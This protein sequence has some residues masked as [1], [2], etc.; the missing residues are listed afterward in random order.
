MDKSISDILIGFYAWTG[1][2]RVISELARLDNSPQLR[3]FEP[4]FKT[5]LELVVWNRHTRV[6]ADLL[7]MLKGRET[8]VGYE[9]NNCTAVNQR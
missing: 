2:L 3:R 1:N 5:A 8:R 6:V 7:S 4:A 9:G